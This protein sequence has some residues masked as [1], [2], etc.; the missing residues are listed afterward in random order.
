MLTR[1]M[2]PISIVEHPG[3][4]EYLTYLDPSFTMPTRARIKDTGL[5]KLKSFV[6]EKIK[7][8]FTRIRHL[9]TSFDL[10]S[11]VTMRGFNGYIAQGIDD[12]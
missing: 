4:K 1:C 11:D 12:D 5:P 2:L 8:V 7:G 6:Q 9:N 10:W 3:F